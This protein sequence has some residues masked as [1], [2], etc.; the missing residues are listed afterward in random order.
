MDKSCDAQLNNKQWCKEKAIGV[1]TFGLLFCKK[2]NPGNANIHKLFEGISNLTANEVY[3]KE[4]TT[5][6]KKEYTTTYTGLVDD[7]VLII[8][9][10]TLARLELSDFKKTYYLIAVYIKYVRLAKKQGTN[11][12]WCNRR[13]LQ[14]LLKMSPNTITSVNKQLK[15]LDLIEYIKNTKEKDGKFSKGYIR[16]KYVWNLGQPNKPH[17][18]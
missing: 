18:A 8:S 4:G 12:I 17:K 2:H 16:L 7:D 1:S 9:E 10:K 6:P 15:K 14:K 13:Y 5:K 3:K 11:Q